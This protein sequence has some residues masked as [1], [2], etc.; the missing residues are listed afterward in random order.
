[1]WPQTLKSY[2]KGSLILY[3]LSLP[4]SKA[5]FLKAACE[6]VILSRASCSAQGKRVTG[7]SLR[8]TNV[9]GLGW[10]GVEQ[11][12]VL[13]R[14]MRSWKISPVF[15]KRRS[16]QTKISKGPGWDRK[17]DR[18]PQAGKGGGAVG[19]HHPGKL[20]SEREGKGGRGLQVTSVAASQASAVGRCL[21]AHQLGNWCKRLPNW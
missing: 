10:K 14:G 8:I 19:L 2:E 20:S 11:I 9:V 3:F 1:M 17:Q 7:L 16:L 5:F 4:F 13:G 18:A 15:G 21:Y 12:K 6:L